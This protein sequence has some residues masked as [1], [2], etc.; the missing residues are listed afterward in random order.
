MSRESDRIL[1]MKAEV[2]KALGHPIR[3]A[4]VEALRD[5]EACVCDIAEAVRAERP[6]VSRH[7]AVLVAAGVL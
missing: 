1:S 6:N 7:L 3:L 5:G 2:F 4:V